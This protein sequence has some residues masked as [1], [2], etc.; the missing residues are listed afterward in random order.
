MAERVVN[1]MLITSRNGKIRGS[2]GISETGDNTK[3]REDENTV[4]KYNSKLW[5]LL[6]G[7]HRQSLWREG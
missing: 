5:K 2:D 7:E 1:N 3:T 6:Q 4:R